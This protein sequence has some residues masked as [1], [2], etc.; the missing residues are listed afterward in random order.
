MRYSDTL[1]VSEANV[2]IIMDFVRDK[3]LI[4]NI[5]LRFS[6][7]YSQRFEYNEFIKGSFKKDGTSYQWAVYCDALGGSDNDGDV[8]KLKELEQLF[9]KIVEDKKP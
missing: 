9:Y 4:K 3:G 7:Q 2:K 1:A 8:K 6:G 5:D